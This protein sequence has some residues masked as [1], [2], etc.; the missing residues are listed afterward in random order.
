[1]DC[2]VG[3]GLSVEM[4]HLRRCLRLFFGQP[5]SSRRKESSETDCTDRCSK[6]IA[7]STLPGIET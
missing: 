4:D 5:V 3:H 7:A 1:M 6:D 2:T